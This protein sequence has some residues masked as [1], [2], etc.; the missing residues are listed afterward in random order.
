MGEYALIFQ[1]LGGLLAIFFIFVT[2]M[3]TKTWRWLH[4]TALFLVFAATIGFMPLAAMSLATQFNWTKAH[5]TL[6]KRLDDT[7]K[8]YRDIVEGDPA[9][10]DGVKTSLTHLRG[11]YSRFIID[12]GRVFR[13]CVPTLNPA[14]GTVTV[15]FPLVAIAPAAGA[16]A[17]GAAPPADPAAAP[18][19][20]AA[21][22]AA[23]AAPAGAQLSIKVQEVLYAFMELPSQTDPPMALPVYYIGQF[24]V[25][26]AA[27]QTLTLRRT[28]PAQPVVPVELQGSW[29]LCE[30]L[31]ID[32]HESFDF[33]PEQRDAELARLFPIATLQGMGVSQERYN[34]MLEEYRRDGQVAQETDPP[35]N[36]WIR[37][38]FLQDHSIV[39]DA[40]APVSPITDQIFDP[41][42]QAQVPRLQR[43]GP[44]EFKKGETAIFDSETANTLLNNGIAKLAEGQPRIFRRKLNNYDNA[45]SSLNRRFRETNDAE[46]TVTRHMAEIQAALART[47]EQI[48]LLEADKAM[49]A[50]D[51][52]KVAHERDELAKYQSTLQAKL[53]ETRAELSRLYNANLQLQREL[54]EVSDRL[55]EE[56]EARVRQA[57]ASSP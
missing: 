34:R 37:V 24:E 57:T 50:V 35:E 31:P 52:D 15:Q 38:E 21:A 55:T 5:A 20:D 36:V 13:Q 17:P 47:D 16:A 43:G 39:V 26:A 46:V 29:M 18:P 40:G 9:S 44:V 51:L 28:L 45:F 4:V 1:I 2:V 25:T 41:L 48:T 32:L 53:A 14:D 12:R 33:P 22:A 10:A 11:E 42:G 7:E 19:A 3:N 23:P 49:L 27:G 6:T 56:I 54:K 8:Q 30:T